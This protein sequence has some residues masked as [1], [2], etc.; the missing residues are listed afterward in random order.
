MQLGVVDEDEAVVEVVGVGDGEALASMGSDPM[1][2]PCSSL[3]RS[4]MDIPRA[5]S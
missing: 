2:V 3:Y 4:I 1:H 5:V